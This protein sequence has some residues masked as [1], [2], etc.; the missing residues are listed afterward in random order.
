MTKRGRKSAAELAVVPVSIDARRPPPPEQFG[1]KEAQVW[2][3]TVAAAPAGWFHRAHEPMLAAYCRHVVAADR[4][5]LLVDSFKDEWIK[6]DGGLQRLDKLLVMRER[7]SRAIILCART[8][9]LTHQAQMHPRS[10]GRASASATDRPKPWDD[11]LLGA[12]N[13]SASL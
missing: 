7:E 11:K 10:A 8:M 1:A 9:R 6:E 13:S 12:P 3:D 5:A 4:L 2:R